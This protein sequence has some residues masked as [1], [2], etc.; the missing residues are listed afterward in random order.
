MQSLRNAARFP[1]QTSADIG[2]FD[3]NYHLLSIFS[4][5]VF[6]H[7]FSQRT[8]ALRAVTDKFRSEPN[9]PFVKCPSMDFAASQSL[10]I[11]KSLHLE[12]SLLVEDMSPLHKERPTEIWMSLLLYTR[13]GIRRNI[14]AT[15]CAWWSLLLFYRWTITIVLINIKTFRG[16][17]PWSVSSGEETFLNFTTSFSI[18][19]YHFSKL[20]EQLISRTI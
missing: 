18:F 13:F 12:T 15:S 17:S 4:N 1:T 14:V 16:C 10:E 11:F 20:S 5:T 8:D 7:W 3:E 6:A 9:T 2:V 19:N